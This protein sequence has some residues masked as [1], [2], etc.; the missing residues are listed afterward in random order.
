MQG[1]ASAQYDLLIKGG[2]VIDP[3]QQINADGRGNHFGQGCP[4]RA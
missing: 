1:P 4:P 3:S 2:K